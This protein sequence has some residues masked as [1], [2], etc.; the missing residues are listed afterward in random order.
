[1]TVPC[2]EWQEWVKDSADKQ[3]GDAGAWTDDSST[4]DE[5]PITLTI[6]P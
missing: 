4:F 5:P 2:D 6:M 3:C 1:M